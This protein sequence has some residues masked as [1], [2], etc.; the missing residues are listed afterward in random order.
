MAA[1]HCTKCGK[2]LDLDPCYNGINRRSRC[3]TCVNDYYRGRFKDYQ[4]EYRKRPEAQARKRELALA[5]NYKISKEECNRLLELQGNCCAICNNPCES[6]RV[7]SVDHDHS[8]GEVRGLL[9]IKC[10]S[11]FGL[12]NED[13]DLIMKVYEY[14]MRI[15]HVKT[16]AS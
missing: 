1:T 3:K 15:A 9:C 11:A 6:G 16:D 7:L 14:I 2:D 8:T 10:N 13:P 12:L 4:A 5:K